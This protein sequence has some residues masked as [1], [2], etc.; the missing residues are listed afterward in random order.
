MSIEAGV[1]SLTVEGRASLDKRCRLTTDEL[2]E[3]LIYARRSVPFVQANLIE[4]ANDDPALVA[5]WRARLLEHG[6][7]ANDPVPLYPYPSSPDYRKLWGT[8]DAHAWER[9]HAHYLGQ[10]DDLSEIQEDEPLPL[11][12]LEAQCLPA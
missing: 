7:W 10:F 3:R 9:A 11:A 1:E 5:S 2:A 4:T 12:A 8:P 6:V